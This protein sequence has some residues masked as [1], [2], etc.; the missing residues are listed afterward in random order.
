MARTNLSVDR[1]VFEAFSAQASRK[2]MTLYAFA[3][4][5]LSAIARITADG[6]DPEEVYRVWKVL[7]I[8][9]EVDVIILPSEFEEQLIRQLCLTDKKLVLAR[10]RELGASLV[11]LLK[12]AAPDVE[13]LTHLARSFFFLIPIKH[14]EVSNPQNGN[15]EV[16]V[17][18]A[19][20]G[21]ETTE[22]SNEFLKSLLS[23]YGYSILREEIHPGVIRLWA[24][25][26]N[27]VETN[28]GRHP[29]S[30][31]ERAVNES[32]SRPD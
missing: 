25:K 24:Q 14:F 10:F 26:R 27:I 1:D 16:N 13:S 3:N 22:C 18:G 21:W 19:G 12:I 28:G 31:P 30:F 4:E 8:M 11:P 17:V 5:S 32:Q 2:N 7:T 15:I 29:G 20:K 9:K 6:G 23:G